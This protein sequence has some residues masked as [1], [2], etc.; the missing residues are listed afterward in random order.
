M[1]IS[2]YEKRS[3]SP[4]QSQ[5]ERENRDEIDRQMR[6]YK[7]IGEETDGKGETG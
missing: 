3:M 7:E 6:T 1:C 2:V 5:L 4:S